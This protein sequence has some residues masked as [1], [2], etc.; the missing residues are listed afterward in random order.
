MMSWRAL[1]LLLLASPA[2]GACV[3][4]IVV[5]VSPLG[6]SV[7]VD[8]KAV[9]GV[10]PQLLEQLGA[11][12]GCQFVWSVVPRVRA[13]MMFEDGKADL[14]VAATR[15]DKRDQSGLFVPL[16]ATRASLVSVEKQQAPLTSMAQLLAQPKLR[17]ALVRGYDYGQAYQELSRQLAQQ[18][19]LFLE[20][21]ALSVARLLNAGM[22][23]VTILPSTAVVGAIATDARVAGLQGRLRF[24]PL[25]ELPWS[26]G[27]IYISNKS[28]SASDRATLEQMLAGAAHNGALYDGYLRYFSPTVLA[29]STGRL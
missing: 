9:S 18:K 26:K 5:P 10:F 13:E 23:D 20:P 11:K 15:S 19:R 4:P 3:R 12:A 22:A 7:I 1:A 8:G 17:V 24:E 14:L 21:D 25:D 16:V 2:W 28:L 29:H 6:V 27:G